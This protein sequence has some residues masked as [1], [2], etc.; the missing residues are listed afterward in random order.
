M[1]MRFPAFG[2]RTILE[3]ETIQIT[4]LGSLRYGG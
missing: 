4:S 2:Y 1:I 3:K